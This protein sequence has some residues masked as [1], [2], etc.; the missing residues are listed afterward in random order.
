[1]KTWETGYIIEQVPVDMQS[2]WPSRFKPGSAGGKI[3]NQ[4]TCRTCVLPESGLYLDATETCKL[5]NSP[6]LFRH[7]L[8][9]PD[10]AMLDRIIENIR[11]NGKGRAFDCM[12]A[13]SGGR[14]S[15]FMLHEL[16]TKYRLRCV[17]VFGKTPFTPR[18]ITE[19]VHSIS[20]RLEVALIEIE[21][22]SN[23]REIAGY[24]LKE[25]LRTR[26][27]VLIN[28]ACSSCKFVNR[29]IFKHAQRLG[30]RSVVYGGNR[31]EYF[32]GPASI[33]LD[34]ENR[35]SFGTMVKDTLLRMAKGAG[36]LARSPALLRYLY[37]F[38]AASI[39]YVNQYTV[40]LRLR[41][42]HIFRFDFY[43]FSDWDEEKILDAL[44]NIGWRLPSGCTST[45]RA[46]C[47]FEAV[48][49]TAFK[50]RLGFTYAQALYSNLIRGGK[51]TRETALERLRKEGISEPRLREALRLCGLPETSFND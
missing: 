3:M 29:E 2:I 1:M 21:T 16:V 9:K 37:T 22:P 46:D 32:P 20:K 45:W 44:K 33:D 24:C 15:T 14:D 26:V 49:N 25:Y 41:Y 38:F 12:V 5:C 30:I 19:S 6:A 8:K 4:R 40:F 42:P 11:K 23:H 48:K 27:P 17:A 13:W 10:T 51:M 31:F 39:L 18:E 28:L 35:Y 34:T 47:M 7:I 50:K 36:I 43:H